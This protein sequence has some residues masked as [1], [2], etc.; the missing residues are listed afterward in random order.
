M[1][2]NKSPSYL[3][4]SV[5]Y[6]GKNAAL[7]QTFIKEALIKSE[8]GTPS[9]DER[10]T[11]EWSSEGESRR[12]RNKAN[13]EKEEHSE[14]GNF[15]H[16]WHIT[17]FPSWTLKYNSENPFIKL[18]LNQLSDIYYDWTDKCFENLQ[19]TDKNSVTLSAALLMSVSVT[20]SGFCC[21]SHGRML[22]YL[23]FS[24]FSSLEAASHD[25]WMGQTG[26]A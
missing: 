2:Q 26:S 20:V 21:R 5:F 24:L 13:E 9:R 11:L 8:S 1:R 18:S 25:A 23:F 7:I 10:C 15:N 22:T 3:E 17:S 19:I 4:Q 6:W 14:R 12:Q 16:T